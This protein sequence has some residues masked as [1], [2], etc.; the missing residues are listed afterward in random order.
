MQNVVVY[1]RV[2]TQGQVR[3]GYSLQYQVDEINRYCWENNW[4]LL[5][6]YE[7]RGISGAK[8][9]EEGLTVERE[10][11]QSMLADIS[12]LDVHGVIVLNI[13]RDFGVQTWRKS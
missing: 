13:L 7:D 12:Q 6:I 9:D 2:S 11:L 5:R 3:D 4:N 10:G 8:V 1:V